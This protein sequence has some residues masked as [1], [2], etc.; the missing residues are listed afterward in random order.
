MISYTK[1]GKYFSNLTFYNQNDNFGNGPGILSPCAD[2]TLNLK[3]PFL[4][5]KLFILLKHEKY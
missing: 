1:D 3:L 5:L 4:L 2:N